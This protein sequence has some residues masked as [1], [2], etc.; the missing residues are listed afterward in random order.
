MSLG[1]LVPG[2][3][4]MQGPVLRFLENGLRLRPGVVAAGGNLLRQEMCARPN[5]IFF[6]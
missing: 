6:G 5:R 2:L 1:R 4:G 3:F